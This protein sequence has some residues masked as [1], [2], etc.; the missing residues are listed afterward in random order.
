LS[1]RLDA[2]NQLIRLGQWAMAEQAAA[3]ERLREAGGT[4]N[5]AAVVD[6]RASIGFIDELLARPEA[7]D[8][9]D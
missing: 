7:S 2:D 9:S 5:S 4:E 6:Y 1:A 3:L 8:E